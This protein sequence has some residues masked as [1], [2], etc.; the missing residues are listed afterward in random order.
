MKV[1]RIDDVAAIDDSE[2][3]IFEGRVS[4]QHVIGEEKH[5]FLSGEYTQQVRDF[6]SG[7]NRCRQSILVI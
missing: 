4:I 2:N 6:I 3:K 5:Q 1:V 7:E